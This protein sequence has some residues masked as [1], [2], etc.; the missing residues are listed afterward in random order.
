DQQL[1]KLR[2]IEVS[3][4]RQGRP[5]DEFVQRGIEKLSPLYPAKSWPLNRELSQIL[6]YLD[7][8]GVIKKTLDLATAAQTQE[9]QLHYIVALRK[10]KGWT[11]DERKRYFS[12]FVNRSAGQNAGATYPSGGEYFVN[13]STK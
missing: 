5:T 7:A 12:W 10:A 2:V 11:I 1:L 13:A 9:E 8:P 3:V 4:A 6:I